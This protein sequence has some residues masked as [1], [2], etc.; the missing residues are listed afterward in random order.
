MAIDIAALGTSGRVVSPRPRG[1]AVTRALRS[2]LQH[3]LI[4]PL[5][6]LFCRLDV[7]SAPALSELRGGFV[8]VA[9]HASHLDCPVLLRALPAE[10]RARTRVAAAADY[11]YRGRLRAA[12]VTA[13]L[14]TV[15]IERRGNAAAGLAALHDVLISGGVVMIF[16]EGTR[17]RDGQIGRFRCGAARLAITAGLPVVPAAMGGLHELLPPGARRPR[18]GAAVVRFGDPMRAARG[19]CAKTFTTRL[20]KAVRELAASEGRG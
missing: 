7:E 6:R 19:E 9:N 17:A 14:G 11:F 1:S 8:L 5:L 4:F 16:P 10:I 15:P 3:G 20:E 13:A 18:R 2:S 12:A